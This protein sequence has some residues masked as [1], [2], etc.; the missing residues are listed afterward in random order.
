MNRVFPGD[1]AG[2]ITEQIA[3]FVNDELISRSMR[4]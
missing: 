1:H 4:Y 3:A 2:T